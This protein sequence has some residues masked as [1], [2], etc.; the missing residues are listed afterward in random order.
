LHRLVDLGNTVV[1]I[2][3]NLDVIKSCDW[4]VD[5]GPE[6]GQDGGQ[7]VAQGTPEMIAAHAE[8]AVSGNG[9]KAKTPK[10][11]APLLRSH[12]G[13]ALAPILAA[14][15][16]GSRVTPPPHAEQ[17]QRAD[18][19][20]IEDVGRD[21]KMPWE[22][23]GRQWHTKDRV[24]RKGQPAKWDGRI[25]ACIVDFIHEQG[26]FADTDWNS[27]S[28]V[29][30]TGHKKSD[31]WFFHAITGETWLI[32]LKFRVSKG[33]FR[34][35]Q[36]ADKI[37]LKTLN[38]LDELPI[39]SNEPRLKV[40]TI[41]GPWQEVQINVH[42][43]EEIETPEFWDF[44]KDAIGGFNK[45]SERAAE[46]PSDLMPWK[47]L[48]QKW[49]F[50]RKGFPPGKQPQWEVGVLE[51]LCEMLT[52]AAGEEGQFLWNN[53]QLVHLYLKGQRDPWA[54]LFTKRLGSVDLALTSPKGSIGFGRVHD[55]GFERELDA[56]RGDRDVLILKFKTADD[57]HRGDLE[58]FL[59]EHLESITAA[60]K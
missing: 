58:V 35:E 26:S 45:F 8:L 10:N 36:L 15:P 23:D 50:L 14:G 4:I 7:I 20:E 56:K 12:T 46:N 31:G 30:I 57:L 25:L 6:A 3:H 21:A 48:G 60:A 47:K 18:D 52:A 1:V 49:H 33:T 29:E 54:T 59:K 51:E 41:R 9:S 22:R 27:R 38:Q 43:L 39:Y 37:K 28:V 5:L 53:Q 19:L 32:K 16:H 40:M 13:E 55:L 17:E 2:E 11:G 34:R 24:D 42:V 44:L